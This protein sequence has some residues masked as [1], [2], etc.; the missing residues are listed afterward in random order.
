[1]S[2]KDFDSRESVMKAAETISSTF[3][4]NED[5]AKIINHALIHES[6]EDER[7]ELINLILHG[8]C[9]QCGCTDMSVTSGCD[10]YY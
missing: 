10:C 8:M 7:G 1:M 9:R 6:T 4:I 5:V 2:Y 3:V